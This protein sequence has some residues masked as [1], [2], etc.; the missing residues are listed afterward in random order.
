MEGATWEFYRVLEMFYN[1]FG[2][3]VIQVDT[4]VQLSSN[5]KQIP[6]ILLYANDAQV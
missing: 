5:W 6:H 3:V 2:V 1:L 4:I